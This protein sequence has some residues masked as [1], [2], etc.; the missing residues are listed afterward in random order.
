MMS[1]TGSN[2]G[3]KDK[4]CTCE[5]C[6]FY[7]FVQSLASLPPSL[8]PSLP[9]GNATDSRDCGK[10]PLCGHVRS[11]R[12]FVRTCALSAESRELDRQDIV[13]RGGR[14]GRRG[15]GRE[16]EEEG[17]EGGSEGEEAGREEE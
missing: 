9:L 7:L 2:Q 14:K 17:G 11:R 15:G 12:G 10:S 5:Y 13:S 6:C 4:F 3:T 8:P 16:G 1:F